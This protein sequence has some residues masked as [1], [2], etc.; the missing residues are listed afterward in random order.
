[1][2]SHYDT[3]YEDEQDW[4]PVILKRSNKND[5]KKQN[6][7]IPLHRKIRIARSQYGYTAH[8]LCQQLHMKYNKYE[9]ME[10]GEYLYQ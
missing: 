8:D 4:E 1:M 5:E 2:P 6:T 3:H 9:K 7:E 10:S